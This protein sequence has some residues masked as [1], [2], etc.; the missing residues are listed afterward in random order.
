MAP[1]LIYHR[2]RHG[3]LADGRS[4]KENSLQAFEQALEEGAK[5]VE[6][7]VWGELRIS[8]DPNPKTAMLRLPE[9]LDLIRG[10]CAVNVEIKSPAVA[11]EVLACVDQA[12]SSGHWT[13]DQFVLSSFHHETA[14]RCKKGAPALRV[15]VI[16]DGVLLS[17]Y[18]EFLH[19]EGIDNL[20]LD[21]ANIYM[22]IEN[23][24][25]L[26]E[27][28]RRCDMQLWI[29]TV[30]STEVYQV[31]SQYGAEAVFTDR[32]DLIIKGRVN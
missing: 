22:D 23:G 14:L 18:I 13:A 12:L 5:M 17:S 10:R 2:G 8:H 24:Y 9:V 20:H 27:V 30:N 6:F 3:T 29:W 32:P 26:R 19:S 7:D 16:N 15:G 21:W 4:I 1:F 31:V 28:A 11:K 25:V